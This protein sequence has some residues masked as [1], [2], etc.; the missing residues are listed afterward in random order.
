M[1]FSYPSI[2]LEEVRKPTKNFRAAGDQDDIRTE[3][4][5]YRIPADNKPAQL[6]RAYATPC[7]VHT[8]ASIQTCRTTEH[9]PLPAQACDGDSKT[10]SW[11]SRRGAGLT[12]PSDDDVSLKS[13][14]SR[15]TDMLKETTRSG[16]NTDL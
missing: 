15:T 8:S 7:C 4:L 1:E 9:V 16:S 10:D 6:D 13:E 5:P 3:R 12:A 14:L 11:P 2:C